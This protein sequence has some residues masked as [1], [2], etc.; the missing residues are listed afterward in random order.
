M[1]ARWGF[2]ELCAAA[3]TAAAAAAAAAAATTEAVCC[4][5]H[6]GLLACWVFFGLGRIS[7]AG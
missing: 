1:L 4:V 2:G 5:Q 7:I 3:A 6:A